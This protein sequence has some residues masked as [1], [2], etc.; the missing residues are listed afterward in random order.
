MFA[1][2][3]DTNMPISTNYV[4][5]TDGIGGLTWL[6]PFTN[7]ST[8][9]PGVGY[10]PS[11]LLNLTSNLSSLSSYVTTISSSVFDYQ[12][13]ST[14][15]YSPEFSTIALGFFAA[16]TNQASNAIAIGYE[17]GRV[18]QG[19]ATI[20]IGS[21][22]GWS[23]QGAYSIAIGSRAGYLNQAPSSIVIS[24]LTSTLNVK[25]Q[26]FY[27]APVRAIQDSYTHTL[28]YNTNNAEIGTIPKNY[29][30]LV[31]ST[32][33]SDPIQFFQADVGKFFHYTTSAGNT[34]N[35]PTVASNGWNVYV[36][37]NSNAGSSLTLNTF[38]GDTLVAGGK[39]YLASDGAK[40]Y[41][42]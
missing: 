29:M 6:N 35:M 33:G 22:A 21:E 12:I 20:A 36:S 41:F 23:N 27:V 11:T 18:T 31:V 26:G 17:A 15:H 19:S 25:N 32:L 3:P 37:L 28:S 4:V 39:G 42:I 14:L 40:F 30:N 34:V 1:L 24:G 13:A 5:T 10:L 7:L 8:A 2:N 38:S 9:G 16:S